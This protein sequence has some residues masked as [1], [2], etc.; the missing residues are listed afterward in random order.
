MLSMPL[1]ALTD[2]VG[3]AGPLAPVVAPSQPLPPAGRFALWCRHSRSGS[4]R[5]LGPFWSA[6]SLGYLL[7]RSHVPNRHRKKAETKGEAKEEK[8]EAGFV[9]ISM[10]GHVLVSIVRAA[11]ARYFD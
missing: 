7:F 2:A 4:D 5:D 3:G 9:S 6:V 10:F 8:E 11:F 1:I